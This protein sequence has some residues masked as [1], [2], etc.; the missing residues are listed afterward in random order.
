[1]KCYLAFDVV[2]DYFKNLAMAREELVVAVVDEIR[3]VWGGGTVS[4]KQSNVRTIATF[5]Y[6]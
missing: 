5:I 6:R 1:M 2:V 4:V 3:Q